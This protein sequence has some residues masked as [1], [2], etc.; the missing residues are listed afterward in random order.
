[1]MEVQIISPS[2][3]LASLS[4]AVSVSL[5]TKMGYVQILPNHAG[6]IAELEKGQAEVVDK[7]ARHLIYSVSSGY[8]QV[9]DNT[10]K[11]LADIS[12]VKDT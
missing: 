6:L 7:D 1:M 4:A 5:P 12:E 2:R 3:V 11:I 9:K 8:V 10:V